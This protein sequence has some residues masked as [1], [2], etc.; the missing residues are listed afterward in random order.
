MSRKTL[1][2]STISISII[3]CLGATLVAARDIHPSPWSPNEIVND[4][5]SSAVQQSPAIATDPLGNA[6]AIWLDDRT[7]ISQWRIFFSSRPF[8]NHWQPNSP[9]H[10][11]IC[12][13]PDI[14]TDPLG[15]A[16]AIWRDFR[17]DYRG[18]IFFSLRTPDGNWSTPTKVNDD[19][20]PSYQLQP[21]ITVDPHGNAYAIW[22]DK[23]NGNY[24][25][26]FSF[27]PAGGNWSPN[28]KVNDDPGTA[29]QGNPAIA[30]DSQG[31]AYAVWEDW[32]N[33]NPDIFFASRPPNG[34]WSPNQRLND[35]SGNAYQLNPTI[36]SSPNGDIFAA[37]K[38]K[39]FDS[40]DIFFAFKPK[41]QNWSPN[42]RLTSTGEQ[43]DPAIATDHLGNTYLLW[44][45]KSLDSNGDIFFSSRSPDG[46]WSP[47]E[48]VN[49]D[50]GNAPQESPDIAIDQ[51]GRIF[52]IWRDKRNG[53]WDI[54]FSYREPVGIRGF[55][56]LPFAFRS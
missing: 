17:S 8:N 32:R 34:P 28:E 19:P 43:T 26:F 15:N 31:F 40:G 22:K 54:F 44:K 25:I 5:T 47:N 50:P 23:R 52:A 6:F 33:G 42:Y 12:E 11:L 56:C 24:D 10:N 27:R 14:A 13:N 4:D 49:D 29:S 21:A 51:Q 55:L 7:A 2:L 3:T 38:D 45:D 46:N 37:W 30:V 48:K 39:R 20:N 18:D 35:D 36:A 1:T 41:N 9:I 16:F 53:N